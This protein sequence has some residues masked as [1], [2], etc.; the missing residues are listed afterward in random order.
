M[1][2]ENLDDFEIQIA[3]VEAEVSRAIQPDLHRDLVAGPDT[4]GLSLRD[5]P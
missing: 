2:P 5:L 4:S 3:L 1:A